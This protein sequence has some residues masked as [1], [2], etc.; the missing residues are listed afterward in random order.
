[1]RK[2][3]R[4]ERER[5][6]LKF[7][8]VIGFPITDWQ[9]KIVKDVFGTTKRNGT[10]RYEDVWLEIP[11]KNG[12]TTF[13]AALAACA[14]Y[15]DT[16]EPSREIYAAATTRDQAGRIFTKIEQIVRRTP[17]LNKITDIVRSTKS[18]YLK[19]DFSSYLRAIS[20]EAGGTDGAE[21]HTVIFDEVHRQRNRDLYDVLQEGMAT[22]SEPLFIN[23]TTAGVQ[24]ESKLC[25]E[26]HDYA[27]KVL[28]G[29]FKD[30]SLY[31]LIYSLGLDEDWTDEANWLKTNPALGDFKKLDKV[32]KS[33]KRAVLI[34]SAENTFRRFHLNQWVAQESRWIKLSA[35]DACGDPVDQEELVGE[36]CYAGLDLST[37]KDITAFVMLFDVEGVLKVVPHFWLPAKAQIHRQLDEQFD[38]WTRQGLMHRTDGNVID[39]RE[40]RN[41]INKLGEDYQIEEIGHDPWNA[42]QIAV[43]LEGDGFT[44][45]P[46]RQGYYS[47]S[48]PTKEF[49]TYVLSEK[50]AHGNHPILR[51]MMDC[52]TVTQD[53]NDN[54]RPVKPDRLST[55]KRID[56]IVAM[57]LALD[58]YSRHQLEDESPY[59]SEDLLVLGG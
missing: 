17:S 52:V 21:P 50:F 10:R 43:E 40:I 3:S 14:F 32:R 51:W 2:P 27:Q 1:M 37:N 22:R 33:F 58:R 15:T 30:E 20:S 8:D 25:E 38:R 53:G 31:P 19:N 36:C 46:I 39:Y 42:T 16:H 6:A 28:D 45:V 41:T 35:W 9:T 49:E 57:I 34:P 12:K 54:I 55:Q 18:L 4:A 56:G 47:M 13:A 59:E 29:T 5:R 24:G 48:A 26:L 44:M 7:F 11:K 23:I